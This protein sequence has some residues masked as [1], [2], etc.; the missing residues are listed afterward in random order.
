MEFFFVPLMKDYKCN[1][2]CVIP[3]YLIKRACCV[4]TC[5]WH[6]RQHLEL[7]Y[8][9]FCLRKEKLS[10]VV[11]NVDRE[12]LEWIKKRKGLKFLTL[13]FYFNLCLHLI[14]KSW[15][16]P[17]REL[18]EYFMSHFFYQVRTDIQKS[19]TNPWWKINVYLEI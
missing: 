13:C 16:K 18:N 11:C 9:I 6:I 8:P 5:F 14:Y 7:K 12:A 19:F 17:L 2:H 1:N 15:R 4:C 10:I 3:V